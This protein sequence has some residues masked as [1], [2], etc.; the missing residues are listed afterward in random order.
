MGIKLS[1][2]CIHSK[3]HPCYISSDELELLRRRKEVLDFNQQSDTDI[4]K[5][6]IFS[7]YGNQPWPEVH[8]L[9]KDLLI[10][11]GPQE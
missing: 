10:I 11:H 1:H 4:T 2:K 6:L 9:V 7:R 8:S 5:F 3:I